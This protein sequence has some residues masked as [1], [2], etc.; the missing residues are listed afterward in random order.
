MCDKCVAA[1]EISAEELAKAE[2]YAKTFSKAILDAVFAHPEPA[3]R[4]ELGMILSF[5]MKMAIH[6][7]QSLSE[8][9]KD[10]TNSWSLLCEL[11]GKRY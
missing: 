3:N 2:A 9:E 6:A 4:T 10:P 1:G 8:K 5:L 11:M 7:F